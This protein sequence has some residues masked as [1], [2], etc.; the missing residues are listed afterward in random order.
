[1]IAADLPIGVVQPRRDRAGRRPAARPRARDRRPAVVHQARRH[2]Q[3]DLGHR[4]HALHRGA[5]LRSEPRG[6][7]G[8]RP[9]LGIRLRP[10]P[11]RHL[12][13]GQARQHVRSAARCSRWAAARASRDNLAPCFG[14]QFFG[15]VAI[16]GATEVM[17]VTL[18]DVNDRALWSKADRAEML[19]H[20]AGGCVA[21]GADVLAARFAAAFDRK[22]MTARTRG[23]R[24][25]SRWTTSQIGV[26]DT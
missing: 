6:V 10:D 7:P 19:Q 16:D 23:V 17:T 20:R 11:C 13:A 5:L 24:A 26:D 2:R 1:M 12:G 8:L 3:H 9:V 22:S 25:R 14:L 15:H 21:R 18:K 4:R